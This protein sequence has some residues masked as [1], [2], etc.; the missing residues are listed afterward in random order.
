MYVLQYVNISRAGKENG[1]PDNRRDTADYEEIGDWKPE[2][3]L[4]LTGKTGSCHMVGIIVLHIIY[5]EI[6]DRPF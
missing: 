2:P 3:V 1:E 6:L 4:P 5:N